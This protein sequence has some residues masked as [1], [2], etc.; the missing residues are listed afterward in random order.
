MNPLEDIIVAINPLTPAVPW[1][2]PN[3]VRPLD[4][5]EPVGSTSTITFTN[6]DPANQPATTVNDLTN[7]GWEYVWH[8]H[9]LGHEEND[10][11][12][13]LVLRP[14]SPVDY[15]GDGKT[16]IA[17]YR[18][19]IGAWYIIPSST[20]TPYGVGWGADPSDIP[21]PGDYDGDGKTDIA[22][23]RPQNGTWYIINSSD[24]NIS[25][26]PWGTINDVPVTQ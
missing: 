25:Y 10:M 16:D 17:V 23:W 1:D 20:G 8:C 7:F 13:P 11:M 26:T 19:S 21:V 12:R 5:T 3:S 15:D 4:V 2:L 22:V 18:A 9:L 6:I 14:A 24:G